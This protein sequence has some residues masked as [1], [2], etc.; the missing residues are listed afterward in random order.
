MLLDKYD[1]EHKMRGAYANE[2]TAGGWTALHLAAAYATGG[3]LSAYQAE[4]NQILHR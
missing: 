2:L 1:D 4:M 3:K